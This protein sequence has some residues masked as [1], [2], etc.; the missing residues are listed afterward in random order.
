MHDA[1]GLGGVVSKASSFGLQ[2]FADFLG[3]LSGAAGTPGAGPNIVCKECG[4]S[5]AEFVKTLYVGCAHCYTAF[6]PK[7]MPMV[8]SIQHGDSHTGKIPKGKERLSEVYK[9]EQQIRQAVSEERYEDAV[10]LRER[11]RELRLEG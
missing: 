6:A 11:L 8:A 3:L 5:Q 7:L 1:M 9:V 10:V 2:S 4:K